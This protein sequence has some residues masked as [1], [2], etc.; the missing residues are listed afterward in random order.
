MAPTVKALLGFGVIGVVVATTSIAW[1]DERQGRPTA[2]ATERPLG[3]SFSLIDQNVRTFTDAEL[4]G[5]PTLLYFGYSFCPDVCP[6]APLLMEINGP[7]VNHLSSRAA[8]KVYR[9]LPS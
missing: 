2:P 7:L 6:T 4:K 1:T 3:G 8:G 5:K 9:F